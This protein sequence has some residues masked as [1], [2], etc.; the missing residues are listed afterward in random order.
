M[1]IHDISFAVRLL[2]KWKFKTMSPGS[3][4]GI[5]KKSRTCLI[6][7]VLIF[8][9]SCWCHL[10]SGH[11]FIGLNYFIFL[12]EYHLWM[13]ILP[14]AFF[15]QSWGL[16]YF[17]CCLK[18]SIVKSG[19]HQRVFCQYILYLFLFR[20]R[21]LDKE[22]FIIFQ[23]VLLFGWRWWLNHIAVGLEAWFNEA[24][25]VFDVM[26]LYRSLI[27]SFV[28][29]LIADRVW[30]LFLFL[31]QAIFRINLLYIHYIFNLVFILINLIFVVVNLFII[32]LLVIHLIV[33]YK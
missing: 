26:Y 14:Y 33:C 18:H 6:H 22:I 9:I 3:A 27:F 4:L 7:I 13:N 32:L 28:W 31:L 25:E 1:G 8:K 12:S 10:K 24:F 16:V 20:S 11:G 23:S 15:F 5:A 30:L 29:I 17:V 21:L 19:L 2:Y